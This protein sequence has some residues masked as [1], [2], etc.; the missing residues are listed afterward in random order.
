VYDCV[1]NPQ[2][3][4]N[5]D[6]NG[7]FKAFVIDLAMQWIEQKHGGGLNRRLTDFFLAHDC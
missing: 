7:E 5:A 3:L 4:D 6:A 2:V 1:F